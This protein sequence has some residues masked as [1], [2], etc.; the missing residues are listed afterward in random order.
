MS[1]HVSKFWNTTKG[2][3]LYNKH[4]KEN[5]QLHGSR[6][7]LSFEDILS[8]ILKS[9]AE[10]S[11]GGRRKKRFENTWWS[12]ELDVLRDKVRYYFKLIDQ[13]ESLDFNVKAVY[14]LSRRDYKRAIRPA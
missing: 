1:S 8:I 7:E 2:I 11:V 4:L 9:S 5:L 13:S 3:D 10:A 14:K 6:E 12:N